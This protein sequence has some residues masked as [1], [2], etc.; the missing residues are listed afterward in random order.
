MLHHRVLQG[1]Q[2]KAGDLL[3]VCHAYCA[4]VQLCFLEANYRVV[5]CVN[6]LTH[7]LAHRQPAI[8]SD[9]EA[10]T[11]ADRRPPGTIYIGLSARLTSSV[12]VNQRHLTLPPQPLCQ[13]PSL[14]YS[15]YC[16]DG[17]RSE[18]THPSLPYPLYRKDGITPEH[19]PSPSLPHCKDGLSAS[20]PLPSL[21]SHTL[22]TARMALGLSSILFTNHVGEDW[23]FGWTSDSAPRTEQRSVAGGS[24]GV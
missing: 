23:L 6:A 8:R 24:D 22:F 16:K 19:H 14:P 3:I 1:L 5:W 2:R 10:G 9:S 21:H 7:A 4:S 11:R 20:A 13:P 17:L 18:H 12:V 15:I